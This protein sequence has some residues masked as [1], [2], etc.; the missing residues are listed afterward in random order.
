MEILDQGR[1]RQAGCF[2]DGDK[3]R[4]AL[5]EEL[6]ENRPLPADSQR[7]DQNP[8]FRREYARGEPSGK[9]ATAVCGHE[10]AI[11]EALQVVPHGPKGAAE[12]PRELTQAPPGPGRAQA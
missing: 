1:R 10:G 12:T 4:R 5:L 2:L 9:T 11:L 6:G 7:R 8:V 3:T